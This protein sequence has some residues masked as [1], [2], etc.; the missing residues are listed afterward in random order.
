MFGLGTPEL[1][2]FVVIFI[3]IP[4]IIAVIRAFQNKEL[5]TL[6]F[7]VTFVEIFGFVI[8]ITIILIPVGILLI[9]NAQHVMVHIKTEKNTRETNILLQKLLDKK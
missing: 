1:L 6:V 2:L 8:C 5:R 9:L 7:A 3:G 4:L